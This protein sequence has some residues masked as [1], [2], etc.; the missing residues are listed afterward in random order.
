MSIRRPAAIALVAVVAATTAAACS[1]SKSSGSGS[2]GPTETLTIAEWTN[3][4]AVDFTKALNAQ[5]E[6]AHP[7]VKINFQNTATANGAWGQLS[8]SLLQSKSVDVLAQFAPTQKAFPPSF[9]SI[10]PGGPA[11]LIEAGQLVD[12]K[13]QPFMK[14]YDM[15]A[16]QAAVGYNGGVYG[17]MAAEYAGAGAIWYKKDL[18]AKYNMTVPTTFQEFLDDCAKLKTAGK[19]P[20]FLAGKVGMQGGIWQG[21]ENQTL[22]AGKQPTDS[23]QVS[24]DR[25]NAFWQGTQ[26]WTDPVYKTVGAKYQQVMQY[27]EPAAAGVDQQTAPGIWAVKTDDYPFLLDGSWDSATILKAN[28]KLNAGLFVLPGTDNAADNRVPVKPDLT[29]VVPTSAPHKDLAMQWLAMF[30]DPAN[31]KNWLK[32]T[33]SMSTEPAV[34][35]TDTPWMDWLNQHTSDSF[36]QLTTPWIPQGASNDAAGPDYYK[37]APIGTDSLDTILARSAAAYTKSIGK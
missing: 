6:K 31:Y 21:I 5:F 8:T 3:P 4:G 37:L 19:T 32:A 22:M 1:S 7:N 25:A 29:W 18:L 2:A 28:P 15:T 17:V 23:T 36:V 24:T 10:K 13:D 35:N 34:T 27:I 9:T 14:D 12:L 20:I 16:Q 33:G 11:A 30:S 26:N